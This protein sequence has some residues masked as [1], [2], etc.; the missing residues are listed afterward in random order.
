MGVVRNGVRE[1]VTQ[2]KAT[3]GPDRSQRE[4]QQQLYVH[5]VIGADGLH[6][7]V[8]FGAFDLGPSFS[9]QQHWHVP[10]AAASVHLLS[11]M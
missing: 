9:P 10:R 1:Q 4:E 8:I 5:V 7:L 3:G 2:Q 6:R 11:L